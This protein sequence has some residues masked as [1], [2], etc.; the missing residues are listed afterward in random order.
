MLRDFGSEREH[1]ITENKRMHL[2]F[3]MCVSTLSC[4]AC[5]LGLL[6]FIYVGAVAFLLALFVDRSMSDM[7]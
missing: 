1:E 4:P 7:I 2:T 6:E 3:H 5:G